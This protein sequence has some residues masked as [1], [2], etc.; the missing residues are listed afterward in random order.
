M[1][2]T[3]GG[4]RTEQKYADRLSTA[5]DLEP[6]ISPTEIVQ[7]H[8]P[9][10]LISTQNKLPAAADPYV[11]GGRE[12]KSTNGVLLI[13]GGINQ[14]RMVAREYGF[15]NGMITNDLLLKTPTVWPFREV[16]K[17]TRRYGNAGRVK[18]VDAIFVFADS[19]DW[20]MDIQIILDYIIPPVGTDFSKNPP[21]PLIFSNP[22]LVW[23]S[24]HPTPRLGQ[25]AFRAALEGAYR[26][27]VEATRPD[28]DPQM[29]YYCI[30]KPSQETYEYAED[31]LVRGL[32]KGEDVVKEDQLKTVYMI[33]DNPLSD[34]QGA[35][36]FKSKRGVE[37]VSILVE[38]GVYKPGDVL[39][40]G[41][42]PQTT[43]KDVYEGVQW[44][45]NREGWKL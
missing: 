2:L 26:R 41:G 7:S 40:E 18:D 24:A 39:P 21:P 14:V 42:T 30:G 12:L 33:G 20:G 9:F 10:K 1:L 17:T 25:G 4:G 5:F 3:N 16:T 8:T 27:I 22:D 15:H 31:Q 38:S 45:L 13:G 37:W 28:L 6:K 32:A 19:N 34:I 23:S 11:P 43:V 44:A 29:K 35:N 36:G